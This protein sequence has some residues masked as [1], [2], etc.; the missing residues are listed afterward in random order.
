MRGFPGMI[1]SLDCMKWVWHACPKAWAGQF[2]GR[3][4]KPTI[5]L[6]AVASYDLWIWHANFGIPGS[7]NDINVIQRSELMNAVASNKIPCV[8]YRINGRMRSTPY[9]LVDGIYPEYS[10]FVKPYS[11]PTD[12]KRQEFTRRQES[13]RKDVERAFGVLQ[14]R[15]RVISTP[16]RYWYMPVMEDIMYCCIILHNMIVEENRDSDDCDDSWDAYWDVSEQ[17]QDENSRCVDYVGGVREDYDDSFEMYIEPWEAL[18]D[19]FEHRLL[20]HDLTEYLWELRGS[21]NT[22][23]NSANT[24]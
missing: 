4:K 15:W 19:D 23:R 20:R 16:S 7:N 8:N 5:V 12:A 9:F 21:V 17:L 18:H 13:V 11:A 1:G 14:S 22:F 6:E 24:Y 10:F 3:E 2:K